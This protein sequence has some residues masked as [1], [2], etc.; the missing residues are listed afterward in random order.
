MWIWGWFQEA[1]LLNYL[2]NFAEYGTLSNP[3]H[4]L[5]LLKKALQLRL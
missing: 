2:D 4:G 3:V 5:M 1:G